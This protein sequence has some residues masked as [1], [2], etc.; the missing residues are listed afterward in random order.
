VHFVKR[1]SGYGYLRNHS[2]LHVGYDETPSYYFDDQEVVRYLEAMVS[3]DSAFG[4]LLALRQAE[5]DGADFSRPIR[6]VR[7]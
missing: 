2:V 7:Q 5:R 3:R 6:R 4:D 1:L